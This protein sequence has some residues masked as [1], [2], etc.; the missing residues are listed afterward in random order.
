MTPNLCTI[1][2]S[3]I[4]F[5]EREEFMDSSFVHYFEKMARNILYFEKKPPLKSPDLN[6][7]RNCPDKLLK[8]TKSVFHIKKQ[9]I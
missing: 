1:S 8:E 2:L 7:I 4:F 6:H 3:L 9:K 5:M